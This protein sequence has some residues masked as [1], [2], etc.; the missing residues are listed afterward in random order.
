MKESYI[1]KDFR[2]TAAERF[3]ERASVLNAAFDRRLEALRAENAG[4]TK[5]KQ[6]HLESQILPGIAAYETL[7]QVMPKNEALQTIHGYVEQR[8]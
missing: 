4:A 8:A 6:R 5:Q 1:T 2:K 3:P 7:Q